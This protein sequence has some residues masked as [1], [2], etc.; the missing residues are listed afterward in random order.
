MR[1]VT[2][3]CR[4]A[5]HRKMDALLSLQPDVAVL[6]E[7]A[8]P[9]VALAKAAYAR[10][11]DFRWAGDIR[12][13]GMAVLSF[14]DARLSGAPRVGS[15]T[16][17]A[18]RVLGLA[19][20]F[21]LLGK[22]AWVK[23]SSLPGY[24]KDVREAIDLNEPFLRDGDAVVAGDLNSSSFFDGKTRGGHTALVARL[25]ELGLQSAYHA[26]SGEEPGKET[27]STFFRKKPQGEFHIDYVFL[28][29]SWIDQAKVDVPNAAQW[30][31]LSD[32][33]PVVVDVS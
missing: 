9:D 28:P 30:L 10:A 24:V 23:T 7:C 13:K 2:W 29:S 17:I 12:T 33:V 3:N 20:E 4:M 32:H 16:T 5:V 25:A 31:K 15:G 18:T 8:H 11:T 26:R 27:R 14:G 1:L 21:N 22:W 19:R 6:Q